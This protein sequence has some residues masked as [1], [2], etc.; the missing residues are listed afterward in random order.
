MVG[1]GTGTGIGT[2]TGML[3]GTGTGTGTGTGM[4]TVGRRYR[5]ARGFEGVRVL[6]RIW[7]FL[8]HLERGPGLPLSDI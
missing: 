7:C 4:G 3:V 8:S 1:V 6:G 5:K 2:G